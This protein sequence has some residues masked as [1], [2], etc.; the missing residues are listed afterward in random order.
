[1]RKVLI[2]GGGIVGC[3]VARE[4]SRYGAEITVLEKF[5]DVSCGTTK[6]NSGIVHAG[7]DAKPNTLK[8]KFN[9]LGNTMFESL[10]KELD[11]PFKRNGA[12]VLCF[13]EEDLPRLYELYHRGVANGVE[14]LQTITGE[15]VREIE[16]HVSKDVIAALY[17]KTSGIVS[18]YEMAIAY[19][20]NAA[21]NGVKFIF[22]KRVTS[23]VKKGGKWQVSTQDGST[24]EADMVINCAGVHADDINNMVCDKKINI[25]PRKG[26]YMLYDKT[27]GSL[28]QRTIFQMP[29]K[30]GKGILVAPTTHGNLITGPT[31]NDVDDKDDINTSYDGLKEVWEKSLLSVPSLNKKYVITQFSGI[32]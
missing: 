13:N 23:V 24:Y 25:I 16:P 12:L 1:M 29:S 17:A 26:E 14:E 28:A 5:N 32:R 7:F 2:I 30:M 6:A 18:P 31:A 22:E 8:A 15:Q 19:A 21:V 10:A 4:L 3:S 27:C 11:F 20:E 9:H